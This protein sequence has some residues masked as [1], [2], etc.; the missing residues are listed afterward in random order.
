[1]STRTS[2][3]VDGARGVEEHEVRTRLRALI[4]LAISIGRREGLLGSSSTM[5]EEAD[6]RKDTWIEH[7]TS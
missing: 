2:A 6:E 7:R 5:K 4:E 1:M 3:S